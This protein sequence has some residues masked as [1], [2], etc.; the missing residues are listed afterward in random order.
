MSAYLYIAGTAQGVAQGLLPGCI[1]KIGDAE[2]LTQ[3]SIETKTLFVGMS[4]YFALTRTEP[5][6]NTQSATLIFDIG[7][8]DSF[9]TGSAEQQNLIAS[10]DIIADQFL[11]KDMK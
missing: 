4:Q 10:A 2:Q 8:P 6:A 1:F 3:A 7:I 5:E 11:R 9:D